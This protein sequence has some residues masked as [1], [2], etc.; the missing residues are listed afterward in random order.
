MSASPKSPKLVI[1]DIDGT[2]IDDDKRVSDNLV[3]LVSKLEQ[4]FGVAF[5]LASSR[6]PKSVRLIQRRLG[7]NASFASFDGGLVFNQQDTQAASFP[8]KKDGFDAF[9]SMVERNNLT[10]SVFS[11]EDWY[12]SNLGYWTQREVRGTSINP[13]ET[14][15]ADMSR[16]VG[17]QSTEIYKI[18]VR[19]EP[20]DVSIALDFLAKSQ[21]SHL[22]HFYSGRP[23]ILEIVSSRSDKFKA[24]ELIRK[25]HKVSAADVMYFGDGI[26]DLSC[27]KRYDLAVAMANSHPDVLSAS[28]YQAESNNNDGVFKFLRGAFPA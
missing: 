6:P 7:L 11:R 3:R 2:I 25:E 27:I 16:F 9:A 1:F 26:N 28:K 8:L 17:S 14:S 22:N 24:C 12:S 13:I 15:F 19:G 21:L 4:E 5:A 10:L 23:S 18:M 20:A